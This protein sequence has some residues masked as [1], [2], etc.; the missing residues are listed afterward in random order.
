MRLL[1]FAQQIGQMV[2]EA[3]KALGG[4][5]RELGRTQKLSIESLALE[6][7]IERNYLSL[8]DSGENSPNIR[9]LFKLC[10]VLD[11]APPAL[12][13]EVERRLKV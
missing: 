5:L 8:L 1:T 13:G 3:E 6:P 2:S 11:I 10:E 9:M 7:G 12:I 4:A